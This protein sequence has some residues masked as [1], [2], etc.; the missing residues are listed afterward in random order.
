M[1]VN[2][3]NQDL[4]DSLTTNDVAK[5]LVSL[6]DLLSYGLITAFLKGGKH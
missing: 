5:S 3:K 4:I 6:Y 2:N 1:P